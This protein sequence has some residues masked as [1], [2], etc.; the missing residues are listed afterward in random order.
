MKVIFFVGRNVPVRVE[1]AN[2]IVECAA[3]LVQI[4]RIVRREYLEK[5]LKQK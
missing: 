3:G 2:E 1:G 5:N 4:D